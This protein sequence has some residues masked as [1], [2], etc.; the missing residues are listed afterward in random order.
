MHGL[1]AILDTATLATL[2]IDPLAHA[3]D[4]LRARPAALQLRAKGLPAR[5]ILSLLRMLSPMCRVA[6]C[7]LVAN[8]RP[9]LAVLG[10][11]DVVH[12]GQDD[13]PI[14]RV[15]SIAPS[16]GVGVST[17]D[18][19][20]L[21]RALEARPRY[22]AFG[23]VYATQSKLRCDP[24]VGLEG[25]RAAASLARQ[26]GIPLV[27]IGGIS[28]ERAHEVAAYASS[29]AVISGLYCASSEAVTARAR[30]FHA[31]FAGAVSSEGAP[32]VAVGAHA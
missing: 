4:I 14:D 6:G 7:P 24:V 5:E 10:G 15:R 2:G 28:L 26:A 16:L 27:A 31:A 18:L 1:Y 32:E 9:E 13:M 17:H 29:A 30:A 20:Q 8:D 11:C 25:L 22:V 12:V 3:R 21:A 23:P 19:E